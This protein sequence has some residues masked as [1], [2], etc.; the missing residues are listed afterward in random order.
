MIVNLNQQVKTIE[1][2]EENIGE[3]LCNFG[4]NKYVLEDKH[5]NKGRNNSINWTSKKSKLLFKRHHKN[6]KTMTGRKYL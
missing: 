2:L 5:K 6:G 3:N 1:F 4:V